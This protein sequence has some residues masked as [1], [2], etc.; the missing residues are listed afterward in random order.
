MNCIVTMTAALDTYRCM[1]IRAPE[2]ND[3]LIDNS[4]KKLIY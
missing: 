4:L 3:Y 2:I 1:F